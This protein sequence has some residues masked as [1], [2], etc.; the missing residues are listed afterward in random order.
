MIKPGTYTAKLV[1]HAISETSKGDPQA[2]LT[3]SFEAGG[4]TH[5]LNYYGSFSE[6]GAPHTIKALLV[7]GLKGQSPAGPLDVGREVSIVVDDEVGQDGKTRSK[8]RW[9]NAIGVAKKAMPQ[10][11]AKSKL[12]ALEGAVM[13]A[14]NDLNIQD[15]DDEDLPF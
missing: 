14:R 12:A 1:S 11:L 2:V 5:Q 15:N 8:I 10:D 3:F 9:V 6:K 7:C 13:A 4:T